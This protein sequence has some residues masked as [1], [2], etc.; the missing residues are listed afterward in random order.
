MKKLIKIFLISSISLTSFANETAYFGSSFQVD[1]KWQLGPHYPVMNEVEYKSYLSHH[2]LEIVETFCAQDNF[3]AS[4]LEDSS[5]ATKMKQAEKL[6]AK[7]LNMPIV[8]MEDK[9]NLIQTYAQFEC[10]YMYQESSIL[11]ELNQ[12]SLG[13][14]KKSCALG[15]QSLSLA[16]ITMAMGQS[17]E[18]VVFDVSGF[19]QEE[20]VFSK[21]DIYSPKRAPASV[22]EL[23]DSPLNF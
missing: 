7:I 20:N 12:K 16:T 22:D 8:T 2:S 3:K 21:Q 17:K 6:C 11:A 13:E 4:E 19:F 5:F 23:A 9:K 15:P 14:S 1:G 10:E 18:V